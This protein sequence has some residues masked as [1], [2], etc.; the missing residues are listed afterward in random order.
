MF[1]G[2]YLN[3]DTSKLMIAERLEDGSRRIMET[4]LVLEYYVPDARGKYVGIDGVVLRKIAVKN[5]RQFYQ[6]KKDEAAKKKEDPNYRTY[7]LDAN[8]THQT[9][10]KFYKQNYGECPTPELHK[11]FFDIEVDNHIKDIF[12]LNL[13]YQ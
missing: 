1:S 2:V 12:F 9:M 6:V 3:R 10:Y 7:G 11:S 4:P 8:I 13:K 5:L